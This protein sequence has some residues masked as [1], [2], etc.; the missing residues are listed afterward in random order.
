MA[1]ETEAVFCLSLRLPGTMRRRLEEL[2]Q[3]RGKGSVDEVALEAIESYL[4]GIAGH[5]ALLRLTP[6]Q[7]EVLQLI[8][9]GDKTREIARKLDISVKTVEMHRSQLMETLEL[10]NIAEVVRFAV[11]TGVISP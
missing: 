9:Q 1:G 11:R 7:R 8:A 6:R 4:Q 5:A 10:R 2:R 3:A